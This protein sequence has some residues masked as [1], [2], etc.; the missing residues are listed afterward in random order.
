MEKQFDVGQ[1][2]SKESGAWSFSDGVA[3]TFEDHISK[4]VPSYYNAIE[5][6]VSLSDHFLPVGSSY[7][8]IGCST[9]TLSRSIFNEYK[10]RNIKITGLDIVP[11]MIDES[12]RQLDTINDPRAKE[13]NYLC[14]DILDF[15]LLD[16][17]LITSV[18]TLQFIQPAVRQIV[19][20]KIYTS[21]NWGG[22]LFLFEKVRGP[23]A[24]FQDILSNAYLKFK[25][26]S[27]TPEQIVNKTLSLSSVL[28]PFSTNG[29]ID[30]L[31]RAGFQDIMIV[32]KSLCF[33]GYL[34]I[35]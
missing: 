24:R 26:K 33:E 22:A 17:S 16:P 11:E 34:A 7:Y 29:N 13:I 1:N 14:E 35:K 23:D 8:D 20:N 21:L 19:I 12:K 15:Q 18:Y 4:S 30:L 5:T 25:L 9:G 10:E 2:I 6:I 32:H 3:S 31:K 28:E 27:F